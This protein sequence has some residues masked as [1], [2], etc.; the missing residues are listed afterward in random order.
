MAQGE[1]E[2]GK[3]VYRG[4]ECHAGIFRPNSSRQQT[5]LPRDSYLYYNLRLI[6]RSGRALQTDV[7]APN[8]RHGIRNAGKYLEDRML[9]AMTVP[10]RASI[11]MYL[12]LSLSSK[13]TALW[14][15]PVPLIRRIY[16]TCI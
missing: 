6:P 9:R 12:P 15:H 14:V 4:I 8:H 1:F 16:L 5:R 13:Y 2:P 3:I 7:W 11:Q 10:Y